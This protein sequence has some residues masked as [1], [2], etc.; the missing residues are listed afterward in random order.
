MHFPSK[1][2]AKLKYDYSETARVLYSLLYS[3]LSLD[4]SA[5]HHANLGRTLQRSVTAA[6]GSRSRR[7]PRSVRPSKVAMIN[8]RGFLETGKNGGGE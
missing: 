4:Y 1:Y 5:S 6:G 7:S 2:L 3:L 8:Q